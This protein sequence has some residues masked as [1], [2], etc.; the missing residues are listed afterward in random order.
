MTRRVRT[1]A[2]WALLAARVVP[3]ILYV[4]ARLARLHGEESPS[5]LVLILHAAALACASLFIRLKL[6]P[7]AAAFAFLVLLVRAAVGLRAPSGVGSAKRVGV[8]EIFYGLLV[9]LALAAW[10]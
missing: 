7:P 2:L 8:A 1:L 10:L 9:V 3:S 6:A 5:L 4:H